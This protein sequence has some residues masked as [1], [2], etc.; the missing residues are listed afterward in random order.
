[1]Q[2]KTSGLDVK[3]IELRWRIYGSRIKKGKTVP[4]LLTLRLVPCKKT[5]TGATLKIIL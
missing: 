2:S 5:F 1:M 3:I 4:S